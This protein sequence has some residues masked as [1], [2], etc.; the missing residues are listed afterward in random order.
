MSLGV[1]LFQVTEYMYSEFGLIRA[2]RTGSV[3]TCEADENAFPMERFV[4]EFESEELATA[5]YHSLEKETASIQ[6]DEDL[7][8]AAAP[9]ELRKAYLELKDSGDKNALEAVLVELWEEY[10]ISPEKETRRETSGVKRIAI[11][12]DDG[13]YA[14]GFK[15]MKKFLGEWM[16]EHRFPKTN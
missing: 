6:I 11:M 14:W 1:A 15:G 9:A 12:D 7:S 10:G 13:V 16:T 2:V 3:V 5:F 4:V 8:L